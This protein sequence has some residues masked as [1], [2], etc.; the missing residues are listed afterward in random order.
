VQRKPLNGITD[1]FMTRL[2]WSNWPRLTKSQLT[3]G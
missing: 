1:Y 2:M 3:V